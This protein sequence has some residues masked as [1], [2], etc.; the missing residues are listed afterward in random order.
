MDQGDKKENLVCLG[1]VDFQA[2]AFQDPL[3]LLGPQDFLEN[4]AE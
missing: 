3:A 1:L 2:V 4:L